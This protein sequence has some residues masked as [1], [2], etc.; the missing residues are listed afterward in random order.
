MG[1]YRPPSPAETRIRL[2]RGTG[3]L[4]RTESSASITVL[5]DRGEGALSEKA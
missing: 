4:E 5:A 2:L 1:E 3:A